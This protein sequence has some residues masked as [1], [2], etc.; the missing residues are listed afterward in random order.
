ME[1]SVAGTENSRNGITYVLITPARNEAV[2]IESTIQSV[3][4]QTWKPLRWIIVSDG[5]TDGTDEIVQ[6]YTSEYVWIELVRHPERA[7][8]NFA[9]KVIAFN[10]GYERLKH[11]DFEVIGNLDADISFDPNY[12]AFL[13]RKFAET[14]NLGVGGTPFREDNEQYNYNFTS[15]EHVSGACQLFRR[16]CFEE[17]G[18]YIPL[19]GGGIDLVAVTT[20]RMKGWLTRSFPEK[21]CIHNRPMGTASHGKLKAFL[22]QGTKDYRL[23]THPLWELSRS[24]YQMTKWPFVLGGCSLLWGFIW[25]MCH[26]VERPV[27]PE[28]VAFRRAE[29][30][31]RLKAFCRNVLPTSRS[32]SMVSGP[33]KKSS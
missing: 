25:S 27:P 4:H 6:K 29:Q 14:P 28:L 12:F 32:M 15:I 30:M 17:I 7:E 2:F 19:R 3:I 33:A 18:G 26:H 23:G 31:R 24:L 21:A 9:G 11:L 5:S 8:R 1:L 20:A 13:M 10:S 16:R 22:K